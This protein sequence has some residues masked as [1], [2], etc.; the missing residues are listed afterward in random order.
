METNKRKVDMGLLGAEG[1]FLAWEREVQQVASRTRVTKWSAAQLLS[2]AHESRQETCLL[3]LLPLLL[4]IT[5]RRS[6]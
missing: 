2:A 6:I 4:R 1:S 5:K 3:L